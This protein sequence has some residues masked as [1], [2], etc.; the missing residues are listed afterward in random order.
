M[1]PGT[2]AAAERRPAPPLGDG[3]QTH[4]EKDAYDAIRRA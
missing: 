4:G 1:A 3:M 2:V